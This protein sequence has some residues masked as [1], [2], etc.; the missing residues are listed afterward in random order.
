MKMNHQGKNAIVTG[1]GSGIGYAISKQLLD[2]GFTVYGL[3][4]TESKLTEA[5]AQL[6]TRFVPVVLDV[7]DSAAVGRWFETVTFAVHVLVNNA[8][9]AVFG[10]VDEQSTEDWDTMV[11]V[12]LSGVFYMTRL[13]TQNMKNHKLNGYIINIASVAG[14][15]G[16]PN[17]SGY[18]ATKFGL[19]GFSE[20]IMKELRP[21]GIRVSC[22]F[23]G[24]VATP[25]FTDKGIPTH[26]NMLQSQDIADSVQFLL[27][28]PQRALVDELVMRPTNPK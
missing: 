26:D 10:A 20:A 19:R 8:G 5:A 28:L 13:A 11:G 18:N 15:I 17:L 16:N 9:L 14:L 3:G 22:I 24:S 27:N 25:F 4:R 7:S 23:P 12:N 2:M 1:A 21:H 6:G